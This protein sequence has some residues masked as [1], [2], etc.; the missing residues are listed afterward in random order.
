MKEGPFELRSERLGPLPLINHFTQR[1]GLSEL[2]D[3]AVPTSD[4]RCRLAYAKAIGVL[5]RSIATER[6]PVYRLAEAVSSFAP[7]GFGLAAEEQDAL[8]DDAVGRS[9]DHLFD[10]DRASLTTEVVIAAQKGF[11]LALSELHNDS[12]TVRFCGQYSKA[13]GRSI[14]GKRA[15]YITYG[16]SKD[17]RPDL[18]Q[19]LFIL[20]AT[21]DG[22]VPVMFRCE[23]GNASDS[24]THEETWEALRAAVGSPDFLY[25]ADSKLCSQEAMEYI[26]RQGGRFV[27]VLPRSRGEDSEFR[28]WIQ[29]HTPAWE[30]VRDRENPKGKGLPRDRCFAVRYRVP[31]QEG[32]PLIWVFSTLLRLKQQQSRRERISAAEQDLSDLAETLSGPRCRLRS[33][34]EVRRRIDGIL[35]R[36]H[37]GRYLKISL[38]Q[39]TE[40]AFRQER[41][42]RPGPDT[43]YVRQD[44][45]HFELT[46]A[47]DEEAIAYDHVS[48]GMYPLLTN[49]R[50]LTASEVF[51]AHKRQPEVEKRF[52]Q[53]KSSLEIAPV[54]LKNEGR[55]EALFFCYFLAL[56]LC[57]LIERELRLAM[58]REG[59]PELPLYPEERVT[60]RPT[61]EQ[62]FRLF[63]L[64]ERHTLMRDG[65]IVQVFDPDLTDLQKQVLTLLGV[66]LS[67]YCRG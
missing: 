39:V 49:D 63:S 31:S 8:T 6:E 25:V 23:A 35:E 54:L 16:Y 22:A 42:G 12:T 1:L 11:S 43:K 66:P 41:R 60:P 20:T 50:S 32:W 36:H 29:G 34:Y 51:C 26:D 21:S 64:A 4:G 13:K 15:P 37:A 65:A 24:R 55:V 5:I 59:I 3:R 17:R 61:S 10:A 9:L 33:R 30:K 14:R 7:E 40:H 52:C 2:L 48:D 44:K 38:R 45:K 19:L 47:L 58:A 27:T 18:K 53:A 56:L 57:A 62:I 28:E 67:A 46:W